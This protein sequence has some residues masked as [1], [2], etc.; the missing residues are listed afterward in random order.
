VTDDPGD[1]HKATIDAGLNHRAAR[2]PELMG[3]PA[4]GTVLPVDLADGTRHY[5]LRFRALGER[6]DVYLHERRDC[7]CGCAGA[8][9]PRT[10]RIE[11]DNIL[12]R[13]NAGVWIPPTPPDAAP[14]APTVLPTFHEYA[15]R[16][17][18]A[19]RDGVLGE[20]PIDDATYNDYL[21]RL[22]VHLLPYFATYRLDEIDRGL[23]LAFKEH[24][25]REAAELRD[26][27]A[28]GADLRDRRGRRVK[29][30]GP[31]SLKKLLD[32]LKAILDEAVEDGHLPTNPA[33]SRRM[34]VHVPK[35][36][37]TFLEIDELV[38]L[39]DAAARQDPTIPHEVHRVA[40][41]RPDSTVGRI[42]ARVIAGMRP[43]RIAAD[44]GLARSTVAFH[45][46]RLGAAKAN[47]YLGRRAIVTTLGRSGVRV[48]EL[49]DMRIGHLR[50][51]DPDGARFHIPDAKTEAGIRDVQMSPEL[52]ETPSSRSA[53][54]RGPPDH[55][56]VLGVSQP[57]RR[58]AQPPTRRRD[59]HPGRPRG[60]RHLGRRGQAAAA[61]D[62]AAHA[63]AHL[64]LDRT[65][66][67]P[68]RRALGHAPGRPRRLAHDDGRLR[69]AAAA[70]R[71]PAR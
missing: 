4:T 25:L 9:N 1:E 15:S 29:P 55:A 56:R 57:S 68:L 54:P 30:L 45:L 36:T 52:A 65:A 41:Q 58:A 64:H 47:D 6:H 8:W 39:E 19:K 31:A 67:E 13:V 49:C 22:R 14:A 32:A 66:R 51:H 11:L 3:R 44:L 18:Q 24:K 38:A 2:R 42:A 27:I 23:C 5:R 46:D 37:R 61:D 63:A 10:A 33:R 70:S 69:A 71:T 62:D 21:W 28:K 16:W 50:L 40:A 60:L 59:R 17:L 43:V 34:R 53:A 26:A 7:P 20:R 12:A 35:P 48:S